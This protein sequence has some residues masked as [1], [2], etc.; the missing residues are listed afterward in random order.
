METRNR[1]KTNDR[2]ERRIADPISPAKP[3]EWAGEGCA[4]IAAPDDGAGNARS[5]MLA[6]SLGWQGSRSLS[7]R[8]SYAD[9]LLIVGQCTDQP[10]YKV[11]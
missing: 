2:I 3:I 9:L 7:F 4:S 5:K 11:A 6:K 8:R 10:P 1:L